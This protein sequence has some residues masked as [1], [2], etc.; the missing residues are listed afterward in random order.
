[1]Y[2]SWDGIEEERIV[3]LG[4]YDNIV[5]DLA[6]SSRD[7]WALVRAAMLHIAHSEDLR[8]EHNRWLGQKIFARFKENA[9]H[10]LD[11]LTL[12]TRRD[13]PN[14]RFEPLDMFS[15]HRMTDREAT[16]HPTLRTG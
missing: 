3:Y 16:Y 4:D 2:L 11:R 13:R 8:L 7:D 9:Q 1:M 12:D 14:P 10:Y 6:C 15:N 5:G